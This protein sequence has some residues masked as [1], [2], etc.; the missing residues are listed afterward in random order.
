MDEKHTINIKF[1]LTA[2]IYK[3][4][5]K[6]KLLNPSLKLNLLEEK[7]KANKLDYCHWCIFHKTN[8]TRVITSF[9]SFL[10]FLK[11]LEQWF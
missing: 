1:E 5:L 8:D 7:K 10:I 4:K 3:S 9:I 6:L 2:H 11:V